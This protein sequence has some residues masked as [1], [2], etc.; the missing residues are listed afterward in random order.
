MT[1]PRFFTPIQSWAAGAGRSR[2]TVHVTD[3]DPQA[4]AA[5]KRRGKPLVFLTEL[6]VPAA[7]RR[8]GMATQ[9]I[10]LACDWA[11]IT[12]TDMWLYCSPYGRG[13]RMTVEELA[14]FY[15]RFGFKIV[16]SVPDVEM[17]RRHA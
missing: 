7:A 9:L 10:R 11:D 6:W 12:K 14:D 5:Y 13:Q 16:S 3:P 4:L 2:S 17:V 8:Q 15:A 1:A